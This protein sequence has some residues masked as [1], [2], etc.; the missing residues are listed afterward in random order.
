MRLCS[1]RKYLKIILA[2]KSNS[3]KI[4]PLAQPPI[5]TMKNT[6]LVIRNVAPLFR[7]ALKQAD[8]HGLGEIRIS[9][10]RAKEIL[11]LAIASQK[12]LESNDPQPHHFA[13]LDKMMFGMNEALVAA[14][15]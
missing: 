8:H 4:S 7:V 12:E 9:K 1:P 5:P 14:S 11:N 10:A 3:E 2:I 15:K 13:H 6:H